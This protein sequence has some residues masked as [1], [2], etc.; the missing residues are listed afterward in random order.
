MS[1]YKYNNILNTINNAL[2]RSFSDDEEA[3]IDILLEFIS[4]NFPDL[5]V[6]YKNCK[7]T[8][9][10]LDRYFGLYETNSFVDNCEHIA[11]NVNIFTMPFSNAIGLLLHEMLHLYGGDGKKEFTYALTD[12]IKVLLDDDEIITKKK[13]Y[14]KQWELQKK[15]ILEKHREKEIK[16]INSSFCRIK[17]MNK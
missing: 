4:L 2:I 14:E 16:I 10:N 17:I 6:E 15:I 12:A 8:T 7:F 5:R 11:L 13:M 3:A 9:G 1:K